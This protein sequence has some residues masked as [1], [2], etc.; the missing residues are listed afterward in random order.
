MAHSSIP[1][2]ATDI[3]KDKT[4]LHVS[5]KQSTLFDTY[6]NRQNSLISI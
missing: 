6:F 5:L 4:E 3:I 1:S 2:I